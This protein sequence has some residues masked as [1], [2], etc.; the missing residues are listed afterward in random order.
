MLEA[1]GGELSVVKVK[2]FT[3]L[4]PQLVT[5][6]VVLLEKLEASLLL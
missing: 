5:K 1:V 6:C 3:M 4:L 2:L